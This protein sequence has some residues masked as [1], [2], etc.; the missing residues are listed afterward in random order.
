MI[1]CSVQIYVP[2]RV[3]EHHV[4]SPIDPTVAV[5]ERQAR[6]RQR[7]GWASYTAHDIKDEHQDLPWLNEFQ[8]TSSQ[9][10]M[11]TT[12]NQSKG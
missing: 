12:K 7:T 11:A 3:I 9:D 1:H 2:I 10:I 4:M 5:P 6:A 8:A